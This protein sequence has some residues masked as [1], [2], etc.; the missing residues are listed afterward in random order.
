MKACMHVGAVL[1][2]TAAP[3]F[4]QGQGRVA[5]EAGAVMGITGPAA[6]VGLVVSPFTVRVSGTPR[7]D[8]GSCDGGVQVNLGRVVREVGNA[9]HTLGGVWGRYDRRCFYRRSAQRWGEYVGVAYNFQ[10]KGFFI[11]VAPTVGARNPFL[12][13]TGFPH[14]YGQI[15]YVHRLGKKYEE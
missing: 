4:A 8:E 14:L 15:G 10:A 1:L 2:L 6:S 3:A 9:K 12:E 7:L 13:Y 11:E 5:V